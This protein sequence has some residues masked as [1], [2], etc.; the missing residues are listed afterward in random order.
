MQKSQSEKKIV[1]N[2]D[3]LHSGVTN[4]SKLIDRFKWAHFEPRLV[5]PEWLSHILSKEDWWI[6]PYPIG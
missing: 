3:L 4:F 6:K 1:E 5:L 2:L